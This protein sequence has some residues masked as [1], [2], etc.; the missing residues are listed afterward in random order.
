MGQFPSEVIWLKAQ[1]EYLGKQGEY[2]PILS[3]ARDIDKVN[4]QVWDEMF[5][6]LTIKREKQES[7]E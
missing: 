7:D 2:F 3:W 1:N 4:V 6:Q 5:N